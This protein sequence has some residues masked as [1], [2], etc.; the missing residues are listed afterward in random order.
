MLS[1]YAFT[2]FCV[3]IFA[4]LFAANV[5]SVSSVLVSILSLLRFAKLVLIT[6]LLSHTLSVEFMVVIVAIH[7]YYVSKFC[8][9]LSYDPPVS[10]C[11]HV[12]G[13]IPAVSYVCQVSGYDT[14]Q[15]PCS[16]THILIKC[17]NTH[18]CNNHI[19]A[20]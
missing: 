16:D 5:V 7:K 10:I 20:N 9:V 19:R 3:A 17:N 12:F 2:A 8:Q 6:D 1:I 18:R 11:C 13:N 15:D 4:S 14:L